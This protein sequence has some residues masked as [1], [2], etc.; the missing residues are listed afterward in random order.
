MTKPKI[1]LAVLGLGILS[2]LLI[3]HSKVQAQE[4]CV[5]AAGGVI[6]C[7]TEIPQKK[8]PRPTQILPPTFT[9][10]FTPTVTSTSTSTP[11]PTSSPTATSTVT[12]TPTTTPTITPTFTPTPPA[13]M[14]AVLPG[15]GIGIF[16]L[17]LILGIFLPIGQ[18]IRVNKRG[19]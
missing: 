9:S 7:P 16:I 17:L 5:D 14:S 12:N 1:I 8:T 6:P 18:K 15:A 19:Y 2:L 3:P 4:T 10:T 13:V 11:T